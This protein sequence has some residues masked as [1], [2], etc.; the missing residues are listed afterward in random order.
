[1]KRFSFVIVA[2]GSGA[3]ANDGG[4]LPKQFQ[5]VAGVPMWLWSA[6]TAA[7]IDAVDEIVLVVPSDFMKSVRVD[8]GSLMEKKPVHIAT[9]GTE[10]AL[11]VRN[12]LFLCTCPFVLVHDAA[13]PFVSARL[14]QRL[15]DAVDENTGAVPL[16]P[17][18]DA[19]KRVN[20]DGTID[21]VER[22]GLFITQTPQAFPRIS[23]IK[24]LDDAI[25]INPK[26]EAQIW[27]KKLVH[28]VGEKLNFK[29]TFP[30]DLL[31]ANAIGAE[32][33]RCREQE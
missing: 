15:M 18:T 6:R 24:A 20:A 10:R 32:K 7:E 17:V 11:S 19:L 33:L 3:R 9:G 27:Q 28:V 25:G 1:M 31:I 30:E 4:A 26:D 21:A 29:V 8:A 22:D 5:P 16:V 23:L 12:G 14:C 2:G 13:R